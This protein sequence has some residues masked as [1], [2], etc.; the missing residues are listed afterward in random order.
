MDA[1]ARRRYDRSPRVG[2]SD[3]TQ[4]TDGEDEMANSSAALKRVRQNER[5]AERLRPYRT[6]AARAVRDARDA[7]EDGS[8]E[9]AELVRA[10]QAA[11]D[12]AARRN[13]IHANAAARRKSRLA[14]QLRRAATA[15]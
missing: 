12:Q 1:A 8:P 15:G 2:R 13:V 9:A 5:R 4:V 10:A 11:L 3:A 6:R 14:Q 7:I